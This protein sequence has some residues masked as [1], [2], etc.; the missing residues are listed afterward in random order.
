MELHDRNLNHLGFAIIDEEDYIKVKDYNWTVDKEG[1][2]VGRKRGG[3]KQI[4]MGRCV[5]NMGDCRIRIKYINGNK[6]DNRKC[7]LDPGDIEQKKLNCQYTG[8]EGIKIRGTAYSAYITYKGKMLYIGSTNNILE[9]ISMRKQ[10]EYYLGYQERFP[11]RKLLYIPPENYK[12]DF[13]KRTIRDLNEYVYNDKLGCY[14]MSLYNRKNEKVCVTYIDID[15]YEKVKDFKWGLN[16]EYVAT[17]I[18]NH[19]MKLHRFIMNPPN[20]KVVDHINRNTLDNRKQNLRIT[21]I[22]TNVINRGLQS[23]NTTGVTGVR[24]ER[25]MYHSAISVN[26]KCI[27]LG[28]FNNIQDAIVARKQAEYKYGYSKLNGSY[29]LYK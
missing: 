8:I 14:E 9:A 26:G 10:A 15:D 28:W 24:L 4:R 12:L 22:R 11:Q 23:N 19:E 29:L 2:I 20:D 16:N 1:F 17:K 27:N 25:G 21:D 18:N 3:G 13:N 6:F 5:L 7:N